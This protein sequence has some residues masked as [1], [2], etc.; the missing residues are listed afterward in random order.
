MRANRRRIARARRT[1]RRAAERYR[2]SESNQWQ[3]ACRLGLFADSFKKFWVWPSRLSFSFRLK[4]WYHPSKIEALCNTAS[5][6]YAR[7]QGAQ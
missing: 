4:L 7:I 3:E 5:P 2:S 6:F 1:L